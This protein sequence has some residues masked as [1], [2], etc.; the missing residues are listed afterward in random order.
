ML[1]VGQSTIQGIQ[2]PDSQ[3]LATASHQ[4]TR[5]CLVEAALTCFAKFG[6][7]ATSIRLI[8]TAAG[9]NSSLISYYFKGKEGL[10]REVFR[11]LLDRFFPAPGVPSGHD[12]ALGAEGNRARLR[13]ILGRILSD[14]DAHFRSVDP[15]KDAATR[16]F[17]AE[18]HAPREEV[19]DLLKSRLEPS[20]QELRTCI[21]AIR[22]DLP[23]ADVDFWGITIQGS[24]VSHALRSE[25]NALVWT[26]ADPDL[27]LDVMADRLTAFVHTGLTCA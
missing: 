26:S 1:R 21:R 6:Y 13:T 5:G 3:P 4:E 9:K 17:L 15:L 18:V 10:Y 24:C 12:G 25:I 22:P 23:E 2:M 16:L 11:H 19:K 14:V 20:V 27:P 8:A 7:D